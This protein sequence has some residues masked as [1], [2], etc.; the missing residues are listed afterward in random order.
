ME[1][2]TAE[3]DDWSISRAIADLEI[4]TAAY[5]DEVIVPY[6]LL[7][8][9]NEDNHN[10]QFPLSFTL[11]LPS[12]HNKHEASSSRNKTDSITMQFPK[13][14]PVKAPLQ[15]HSFRCG[16]GNSVKSAMEQAV[17]AAKA[18]AS[19]C[20]EHEEEAGLMVCQAALST[21]DQFMQEQHQKDQDQIALQ[22]LELQQK[23][24]HEM[25]E[26]GEDIQ[27]ISS[28]NLIVD[29]K[30]TFQ[31]HITVIDSDDMARRA[32]Q[33]LIRGSSKI[34]RATHNMVSHVCFSIH[35]TQTS[36]GKGITFMHYI[37]FH[38]FF[39]CK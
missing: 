24:A 8:N 3:S 31:A 18:A 30:S 35:I 32:L 10:L 22:K 39:M 11:E 29:R 20:F 17:H 7:S 28:N 1:I 34:Q 13:G 26:D 27:W 2:L 15:I 37:T 16:T 38:S 19:E 9:E 23:Y 36:F 4:L 6:E 5:P 12:F 14:Y 21:W 33:K 25:F